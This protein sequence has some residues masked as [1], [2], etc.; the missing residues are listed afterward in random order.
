MLQAQQQVSSNLGS[1][2]WMKAYLGEFELRD[3]RAQGRGASR[4]GGEVSSELGQRGERSLLGATASSF[5]VAVLI[6]GGAQGRGRRCRSRGEAA[7]PLELELEPTTTLS[8]FLVHLAPLSMS[9]EETPLTES[10]LKEILAKPAG[11]P[12]SPR[13]RRVTPR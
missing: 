7:S 12:P 10:Q 11:S 6:S 5:G 4:D 2:E 3:W 8:L 9:I 1:A 13:P